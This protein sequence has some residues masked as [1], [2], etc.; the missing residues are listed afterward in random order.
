MREALKSADGLL[1]SDPHNLAW[2]F[3]IRGAD[4]SHTP[5]PLGFAYIPREGRPIIVSRRPETDGFGARDASAST[6]R[7]CE[8][9]AL[10]AFVEKLG[11]SGRTGGVRRR[12]RAG[13]F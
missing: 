8:P 2:L 10:L 11:A 3:N 13:A 9:G 5:L 7:S 12:H 1:V 4:V 6:P